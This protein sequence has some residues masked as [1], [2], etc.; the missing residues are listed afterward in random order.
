MSASAP[1]PHAS[2]PTLASRPLP[3]RVRGLLGGI[4]EYASDE[5]ERTLV[6]VL[7]E[8][9]QQLFKF[10]EQARSNVVQ[11]RWLE[12]QRLVKRARPDLVPRFLIALEAELACIKDPP[13]AKG[14]AGGFR[15]GGE[16]TLVENMDLDEAT[17][18][19]EIAGRAEVRNSLPLYLLGQ[20][21]GVLAGKPAYDAENLPIG[22]QALCRTLRQASEC[23]ELSGEHR[24]L[25]FR[26]FER[27]LMPLYG[28]FVESVNTY[29]SR[30]GVLPN[31]HYVPVRA[32][33]ASAPA[34]A[35]AADRKPRPE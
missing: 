33:P 6:A 18:L 29:L 24:Q 22:P 2:A 8:F 13:G 11:T 17:V 35:P 15:L 16:M 7:N 9:E 21:F 26:T 32:R 5:M 10:A 12:A 27:H 3:E 1:T 34:P 28:S 20:R 19:S 23:L 4:L 31:L 30:N 14:P 25:L